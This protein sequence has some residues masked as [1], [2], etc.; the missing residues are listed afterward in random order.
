MP[1]IQR[2]HSQTYK[3]ANFLTGREKGVWHGNTVLLSEWSYSAS[4]SKGG[5]C[6]MKQE[7]HSEGLH[8]YSTLWKSWAPLPRTINVF[9]SENNEGKHHGN[10]RTLVFCVFINLSSIRSVWDLR[11][12]DQLLQ[13]NETKELREL[14]RGH[15]SLRSHFLLQFNHLWEMVVQPVD[16]IL[17]RGRSQLSQENLL[18]CSLALLLEEIYLLISHELPLQTL[19]VL[20]LDEWI[21]MR[22]MSLHKWKNH[23]STAA[24]VSLRLRTNSM[25]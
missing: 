15:L 21:W 22:L 7:K 24:S 9:L 6:G 14:L 5:I 25:R 3:Q 23:S 10:I 18:R 16:K 4:Q 11:S 13:I 8:D 17:Q 2:H 19:F 20:E 12:L 1:S